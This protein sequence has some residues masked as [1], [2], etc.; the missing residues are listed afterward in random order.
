MLHSVLFFQSIQT[1]QGLWVG[2]KNCQV[3]LVP[4]LAIQTSPKGILY[5]AVLK[6]M[7]RHIV[8][9]F[10]GNNG[11]WA[12]GTIEQGLFFGPLRFKAFQWEHFFS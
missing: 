4:Q 1:K 9:V 6:S 5:K 11:F 8:Y 3:N 10:K 2:G 12:V 7:K